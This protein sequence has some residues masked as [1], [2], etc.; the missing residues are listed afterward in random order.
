MSTYP[1]V[2][3]VLGHLRARGRLSVPVV[4]AITDL[5]GLRYWV[6]PGVDLHL[7]T[8]PESADEVRAIAPGT[9]WSACAA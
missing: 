9:R 8:E 3:E 7:I 1:G 4:S 5:A 2:T 6:H